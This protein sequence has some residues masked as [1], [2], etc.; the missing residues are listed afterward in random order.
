[1]E[2]KPFVTYEQ[3]KEIVKSYEIEIHPCKTSNWVL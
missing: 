1:M 3:L 2:K